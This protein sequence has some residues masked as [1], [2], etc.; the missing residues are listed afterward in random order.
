[1]LKFTIIV[2]LAIAVIR[3]VFYRRR[4]SR[5]CISLRDRILWSIICSFLPLTYNIDHGFET[6]IDYCFI[7]IG[8][9]IFIAVFYSSRSL[10]KNK[11]TNSN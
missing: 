1:M 6:A 7:P 3:F 8:I 4:F 10:P 9:V 2:I 11:K 5:K